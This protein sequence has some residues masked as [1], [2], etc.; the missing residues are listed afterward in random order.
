[1][2]CRVKPKYNS[3]FHKDG[4]MRRKQSSFDVMYNTRLKASNHVNKTIILIHLGGCWL[5]GFRGMIS[6]TK[7]CPIRFVRSCSESSS[8]TGA[9]RFYRRSVTFWKKISDLRNSNNG[10]VKTQLFLTSFSD[11]L[12]LMLCSD[13]L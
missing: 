2:N 7:C 5:F 6:H 9:D 10:T 1:M 11:S 8:C 13:D 4:V 12:T 3:H